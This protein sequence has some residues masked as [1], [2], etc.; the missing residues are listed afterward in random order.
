MQIS[1]RVKGLRALLKRLLFFLKRLRVLEKRFHFNYFFSSRRGALRF[2]PL[3]PLVNPCEC[4][5]EDEERDKERPSEESFHFSALSIFF[6]A[7]RARLP[8]SVLVTCISAP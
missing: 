3:T 5:G 4:S 1:A 2:S 6:R 7:S 8:K